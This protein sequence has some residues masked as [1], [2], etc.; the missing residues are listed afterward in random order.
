MSEFFS[1]LLVMVLGG[2]MQ[3][4]FTVPQ[5]RLHGWSWPAGWLFYSITAMVVVP[6]LLVAV[7][8]PGGLKVYSEVGAGPVALAAVF[9]LGWGIGSVLFGLGV[10]AVGTALGFAI[11]TSLTAALGALVPLAILHPE[12]AFSSKGGILLLG[13]AIVIV[14][15]SLCA[16]AGKLKETALHAGEAKSGPSR[17]TKGLV[18]CVAS[19]LTSPMMNFGFA[20][21]SPISDAAVRAG[22][23]PAHAS[24]A[25]FAVAVSAGFFINAGYCIYLLN[26]DQGWQLLARNFSM[27]NLLLAILMG[28]L[29]MF[30]MFLYGV[31]ATKLGTLGPVLGWPVFM[32]VMVLIA[33]LWGFLTGEWKNAGRQAL[34]YLAVGDAVMIVA[35]VVIGLAS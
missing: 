34:R 33:N 12:Q 9:G 13:L 23:I 2:A 15:V 18:I 28:C 24:I 27:G 26:R 3:G 30:G 17:F 5:K 29:W 4:S 32:T 8:I 25:I 19:G 35:L 31:G 21:G 14:G 10:A 20:F 22:A 1:G 7:T 6:W 11:I 16:K